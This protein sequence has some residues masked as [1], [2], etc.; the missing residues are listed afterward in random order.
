MT[1]YA[2][3]QLSPESFQMF[4]QALLVREFP[5]VQCFPVGMPDGGRDAVSLEPRTRREIFQV[6]QARNPNRLDDVY[7]WLTAAID[8]ERPKVERLARRGYQTYRL[9]TNVPGSAHLDTGLIDRIQRYLD[10]TLPVPAKV[11]WRDDLDR[12]L[13][14]NFDLKLRYP[15]LLTGPDVMR[16]LWEYGD[17]ITDTLR[18]KRIFEKYMK[19][20]YDDDHTVRFKQIDLESTELFDLFVDVPV[21][22]LLDRTD[23]QRST[24]PFRVIRRVI[25][26]SVTADHV[27]HYLGP[28]RRAIGGASLLTNVTF[29]DHAPYVVIEGAPGQ[30]KTTLSQYLV[31]IQ[32][33]RLLERKGDIRK[34]PAAH[35]S[36]PIMLP[37]KIELRDL[38]QWLRGFDPWDSIPHVAH[39]QKKTLESAIA[40]HIERFSGGA[41]FSVNDLQETIRIMPTVILLD[42]LDEVADLADRRAVVNE[43]LAAVNRLEQANGNL[44]VI[45]TSRPS[46]VTGAPTLPKSRFTHLRLDAISRGI[47]LSYCDKWAKARRLKESVRQS[48][49]SA[50]EQKLDSAHLADLARNTMQLSILLNLIYARGASLPDKRTEMYDEYVNLFFSREAEKS[51]IVRNNRDLLIQI[52]RYLAYDLHSRAE[53]RKATGRISE[54]ELRRLLKEYLRDAPAEDSARL[55][56]ELFTGVTERVVALVSRIEGTYEFEVQPLREYFA[57]RYLYNTAPY[58]PPG[59]EAPGTKPIR[60]EALARNPYWFNV[61]RFFAGCFSDGE[62]LDLAERVYDLAHS[63]EWKYCSYP[64][65]LMAA[66]LQDLVFSQSKRAA[67]RVASTLRAEPDLKWI[68]MEVGSLWPRSVFDPVLPLSAGGKELVQT[69]W[70]KLLEVRHPEDIAELAAVIVAHRP[71][72]ERLAMW[73]SMSRRAHAL[74]FTLPSALRILD[75]LEE[76]DVVEVLKNAA[77]SQNVDSL[78]RELVRYASSAGNDCLVPDQFKSIWAH[79]ILE[80]KLH[81]DSV[82]HIEFFGSE[83]NLFLQATD[84]TNWVPLLRRIYYRSPR[85]RELRKRKVQGG[86]HLQKIGNWS[87]S[88]LSIDPND[89][90]YSLAPWQR[91]IDSLEKRFGSTWTSAEFAL[92][93]AAIRSQA[94]RGRGA[95]RLLDSKT[96]LTA[97]VRYARRQAKNEKWWI[98][99]SDDIKSPMDAAIYALV[100]SVWTSGSVFTQLLQ[101]VD[102]VVAQLPPRYLSNLLRIAE[103]AE[104]SFA[105]SI[106]GRRVSDV[107]ITSA[108]RFEPTTRCLLAIRLDSVSRQNHGPTLLDD[109]EADSYIA[110]GRARILAESLDSDMSLT[111]PTI[112]VVKSLHKLGATSYDFNVILSERFTAKQDDL[113][114]WQEILDQPWQWP[115]ALTLIAQRAVDRTMPNAV[116][117]RDIAKQE[118]WF[119]TIYSLK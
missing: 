14:A 4:V 62:L 78:D 33:A 3:E 103:F 24:V 81:Q 35:V 63:D 43:L 32:R 110:E 68:S 86:E 55:V 112:A 102:E 93:A 107:D 37:I 114:V 76:A 5:D 57:A 118:R 75:G 42:A 23:P 101:H 25:E 22:P 39:G 13:D 27:Y 16:L 60:F 88:A 96:P 99:Q 51:E 40:A 49:R 105:R 113:P 58:S 111:A 73:R 7:K 69:A 82:P 36:S 46:A 1:T 30:G 115:S 10:E 47:A 65:R 77:T 79:A 104:R 72:E 59:R 54:N 17:S 109:W 28:D 97:R 98:E 26:G 19:D 31:Q 70:T 91:L 53:S 85:L 100:A 12:R 20:Q 67:E 94:E 84:V 48:V 38:A 21:E 41:E 116:A 56:D 108:K 8:N 71:K 15:D 11:W 119:E 106:Q 9:V 87:R 89:F 29:L 64:R 66:L 61:T 6:K 90:A 34:L 2:Y 52:H 83:A 95:T 18:R 45:V 92:A 50:L 80:N 74:N 44:K 117:V